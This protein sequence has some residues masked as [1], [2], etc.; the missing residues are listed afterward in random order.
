MKNE[1]CDEKGNLFIF[2]R[3]LCVGVI[4]TLVGLTS[5]LILFNIFHLNYWIATSIGNIIGII[6]SFFLNKRYTFKYNGVKA[7]SLF[8]FLLVSLISYIISYSLGYYIG[9]LI[10]NII[11]SIEIFDNFVIIFS[12]GI[13]TIIGFIGHKK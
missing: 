8:K 3:Y 5:I 11:P 12:S 2:L 13:Y 7:Q 9:N 4:N 1:V 10:E 6:V